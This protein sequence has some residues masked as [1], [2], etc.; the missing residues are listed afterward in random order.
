MTFAGLLMEPC[1]NLYDPL[2]HDTSG[3]GTAMAF[4][5]FTQHFLA[6]AD[7]EVSNADKQQLVS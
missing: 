1:E 6:L 2:L 5:P 7:T 3:F 4:A